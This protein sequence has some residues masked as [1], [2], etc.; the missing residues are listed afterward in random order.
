MDQ[1][2]AS[3]IEAFADLLNDRPIRHLGYKTPSELFEQFLDEVYAAEEAQPA[4]AVKGKRLR[5][6]SRP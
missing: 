3:E 2:H 5:R 6:D 1:Y 4:A